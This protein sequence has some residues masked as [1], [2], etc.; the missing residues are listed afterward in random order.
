[1]ADPNTDPQAYV[2]APPRVGSHDVTEDYKREDAR[3]EEEHAT[4]QKHHIA[5]MRATKREEVEDKADP[6]LP[7]KR[8]GQFI[9]GT[10]MGSLNGISTGVRRGLWLGAAVG[11]LGCV[12]VG[13][14]GGGIG[15][16]VGG[17][18]ATTVATGALGGVIGLATGGMNGIR[19][20]EA[21]AKMAEQQHQAQ[22]PTAQHRR[23]ERHDYMQAER[24]RG[25]L[26]FDRFQQQERENAN[27]RAN[28]WQDRVSGDA[29][30]GMN[31]GGGW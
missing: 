3:A 5:R 19:R 20:A 2:P 31:R 22:Q 7:V 8:T 23:A 16:L 21:R 29:G 17:F 10:V 15:L 25:T 13:F 6:L 4:R 18:L 30:M 1:M 26:N 27:D 11:I 24:A 9:G 14:A 28:Y 12:A